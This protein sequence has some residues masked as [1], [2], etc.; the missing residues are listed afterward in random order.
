[1]VMFVMAGR[2]RAGGQAEAE[3]AHA[4]E[5][6]GMV[7]VIER[8]VAEFRQAELADESVVLPLPLIDYKSIYNSN[9]KN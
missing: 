7:A 9:L 8:A 1:M 3:A 2:Q 6:G 5:A 4:R